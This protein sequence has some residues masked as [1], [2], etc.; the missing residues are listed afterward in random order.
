MSCGRVTTVSPDS[1][2]RNNGGNPIV[3][4][5]WQP[6]ATPPKARFME[7]GHASGLGEMEERHEHD[8]PYIQMV[9]SDSARV[10][11]RDSAQLRVDGRWD[12]I[13]RV[14]SDAH[15]AKSI[16]VTS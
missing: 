13:C 12:E 6:G 16:N 15:G 1:C 7:H 4:R 14:R 2:G 5:G 3:C 11:G 10:H 8:L 9:R